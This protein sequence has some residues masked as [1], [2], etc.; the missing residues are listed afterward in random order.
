M[1]YIIK[2]GKKGDYE[3]KTNKKGDTI[4]ASKKEIEKVSKELHKK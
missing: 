2:N 3:P 1:K 4:P